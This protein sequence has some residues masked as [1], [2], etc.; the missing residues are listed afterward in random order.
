[1]IFPELQKPSVILN[2]TSIPSISAEEIELLNALEE[3][4]DIDD[5]GRNFYWQVVGKKN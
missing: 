2:R 3:C 4:E 5:D 1:M